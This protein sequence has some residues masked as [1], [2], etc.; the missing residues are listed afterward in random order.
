[1]CYNHTWII[2]QAEES[3]DGIHVLAHAP[4]LENV[5][6]VLAMRPSEGGRIHHTCNVVTMGELARKL[7]EDAGME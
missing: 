7:T 3:H 5:C 2:T 6:D 1:M 4:A